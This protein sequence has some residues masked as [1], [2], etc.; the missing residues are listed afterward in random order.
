M[1]EVWEGR[2]RELMG[3]QV[4]M[5]LVSSEFVIALQNGKDKTHHRDKPK[6]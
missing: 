3:I 4:G 6:N 5:D 1:L 2:A